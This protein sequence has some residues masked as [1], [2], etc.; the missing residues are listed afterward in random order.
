MWL[1]TAH[2]G[3][4]QRPQNG[5]VHFR[6]WSHGRGLTQIA[7]PAA[8]PPTFSTYGAVLAAASE[9]ETCM[10]L[11]R[12]SKLILCTAS[13]CQDAGCAPCDAAMLLLPTCEGRAES[14]ASMDHGFA[15]GRMYCGNVHKLGEAR[16]QHAVAR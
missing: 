6:L 2:G 14:G 13:A 4:W 3:Q 11:L 15:N 7:M 8:L 10:C 12:L 1:C 9:G 5:T 16:A